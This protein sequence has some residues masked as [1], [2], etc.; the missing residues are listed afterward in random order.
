MNSAQYA[1]FNPANPTDQQLKVMSDRNYRYVMMQGFYCVAT[2]GKTYFE[3]GPS[4]QTINEAMQ[5][6]IETYQANDTAI[7][8]LDSEGIFINDRYYIVTPDPNCD[9]VKAHLKILNASE[10][11]ITI[12]G[13][14]KAITFNAADNAMVK[15]LE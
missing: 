10:I 11:K 4:G 12:L 15:I 6:M 3:I 2:D 13:N 9:R 8:D 7:S 1:K 5:H 14:D